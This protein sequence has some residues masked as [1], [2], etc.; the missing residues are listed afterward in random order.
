MKNKLRTII[1]N[2]D[3]GTYS[4]LPRTVLEVS[5]D[6]V[7]RDSSNNIGL[8]FPR[9]NRIRD[10]KFASDCNTLEDVEALE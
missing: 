2:V 5:A 7:T 8:R 9:C 4:F 1:S 6:L 3:N 10:D